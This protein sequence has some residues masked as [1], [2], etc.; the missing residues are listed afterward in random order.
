MLLSSRQIAPKNV[1]DYQESKPDEVKAFTI[2]LCNMM[3]IFPYMKK[4][5]ITARH[6]EV[7]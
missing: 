6:E 4:S 7:V 1:S 5:M 3:H 2:G